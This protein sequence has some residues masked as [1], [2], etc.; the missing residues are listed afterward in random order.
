MNRPVPF[1][2]SVEKSV[3]GSLLI[4]PDITG[5]AVENLP[6]EA[7]YVAR[8]KKVYS[9]IV[10][11]FDNHG[12]PDLI[13]IA[14]MLR[15]N[16]D[17]E[18][19]GGES[20]LSE[21][22]E[23]VNTS[24]NIGAWVKILVSLTTKRKIIEYCNMLSNQAYQ[25]SV[26]VESVV[27]QLGK[28]NENVLDFC[29]T[30]GVQHRKRGVVV[31]IKNVWEETERFHK[32][33]VEKMGISIKSWPMFSEYYRVIKGLLCIITGIPTHGKTTFLDQV[34]TETVV[35]NNF[36]WAVFSPENKPHYLHIKPIAEK[37][38]SK[39]FFGDGGINSGELDY[40]RGLL[41]NNL[42]FIEPDN[43]NKS[44]TEI[45]RLTKIAIEEYG[46]DGVIIDPWNKVLHDWEG[47]ET[48][49]IKNELM[50]C[51]DFA[52]ENNVCFNIVVHPKHNTD[53]KEVP[54][55]RSIDGSAH[56]YNSADSI[57]T[58]FRNFDKNYVSV[59]QQKVKFVGVHGKIG[60]GFFRYNNENTKLE[61]VSKETAFNGDGE[62]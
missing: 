24:P 31:T 47:R 42:F 49:Y 10:D 58:V 21:L 43:H 62:F 19:C 29:E 41:E 61:E 36:K 32:E 26:S 51:Q 50:K 15:A 54:T 18:S 28:V 27:S 12:I 60:A 1:S 23:D 20:Y 5:Y 48:I 46:V 40:V 25:E 59:H 4:L 52:R 13:S 56:W 16:N 35:N 53:P 3:L 34:V 30:N 6:L 22:V 14:E 8:N 37:I 17:L 38:V 44:L 55:P 2:E 7:F 33:G 39:K 45:K 11:Y 57:T 9:A